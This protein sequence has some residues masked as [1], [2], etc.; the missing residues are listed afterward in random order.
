MEIRIYK[1]VVEL[2]HTVPDW[3]SY[4]DKWVVDSVIDEAEK[5]VEYIEETKKNTTSFGGGIYHSDRLGDFGIR[6]YSMG[7]MEVD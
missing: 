1:Q 5:V 2:G 3:D 6:Y 4:W 7:T